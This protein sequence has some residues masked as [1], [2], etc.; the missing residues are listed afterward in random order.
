MPLRVGEAARVERADRIVELQ[1]LVRAARALDRLHGGGGQRRQRR[2]RGT[3]RRARGSGS[4]RRGRRGRVR[5][6]CRLHGS[7][8]KR[9]KRKFLGLNPLCRHHSQGRPPTFAD[10]LVNCT[11]GHGDACDPSKQ[12]T[13][14]TIQLHKMSTLTRDMR[15]PG[16]WLVLQQSAC[17]C[18]TTIRVPTLVTRTKANILGEGSNWSSIDLRTI[19]M[20]LAL[21]Q[22]QSDKIRPIRTK[23]AKSE[24]KTS[25]FSRMHETEWESK[26]KQKM[27]PWNPCSLLCE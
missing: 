19:D 8:G 2:R 7:A 22:K 21:G 10:A 24:K 23:D 18:L 5:H 15:S 27:R 13:L 16:A 12:K 20:Y 11:I 1:R 14:Q 17:S 6:G 9:S 25:A 4:G 26:T 3:A